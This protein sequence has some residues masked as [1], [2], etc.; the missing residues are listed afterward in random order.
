MSL[1]PQTKI[2]RALKINDLLT[3]L[4]LAEM[5]TGARQK[6]T[7]GMRFGA[8]KGQFAAFFG[9]ASDDV[10]AAEIAFTRDDRR[11]I[12]RAAVFL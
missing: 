8:F 2:M 4:A 3:D 10:Q 1:T 6:R 5:Q 7:P 12:F 9:A 11:E